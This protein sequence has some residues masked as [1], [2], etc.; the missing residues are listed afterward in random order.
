MLH[1]AGVEIGDVPHTYTDDDLAEVA[2]AA[3]QLL[4]DPLLRW[5]HPV[6]WRPW[7]DLMR[8]CTERGSPAIAIF[9]VEASMAAAL[10]RHSPAR[11]G[12]TSPM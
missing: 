7:L 12:E 3:G 9:A 1:A 2:E 8:T 4:G 6:M 10:L 11:K 5:A